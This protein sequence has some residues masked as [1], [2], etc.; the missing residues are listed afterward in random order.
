MDRLN[1][2]A[3]H[4]FARHET[5]HPRYGWFSKA[6]L[7]A[8]RA[9]I[10]GKDLFLA[11]DATVELGV[12]KNM[13]K[14][15]RFWGWAAKLLAEKENPNNTRVPLTV[16]SLNG[17]AI[18]DENNG[19]DP[20]IELPGTLWVLHWWMLR[21]ITKLPVWWLTFH[22]FG[23]VEFIEED[24]IKFV[25][26]EIDKAGWKRPS[27]SSIRKD[28]SCLLRM[29]SRIGEDSASIDDLL[30]CPM[31]ELGLIE[32]SRGEKNRY[33]FVLGSKPTLP[34]LVLVY[35][36]LDWM[37]LQGS[38]SSTM[39]VNRLATAIGS[40]GRAF[41]MNEAS[42][43]ETLGRIQTSFKTVRLSMGAGVPMLACDG[44]PLKE[45]EKALSAYYRR[46]N[47]RGNVGASFGDDAVLSPTSKKRN[48]RRKTDRAYSTRI[49]EMIKQFSNINSPL[50]QKG[51]SK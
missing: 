27:E 23:A 19:L 45:A 43:L 10:E 26:D 4:A 41:R 5:F 40:P 12:G 42:L 1:D 39:T 47:C 22:R 32:P 33:R 17:V 28:V 48:P 7:A 16:P 46:A 49:S 51:K 6:Y 38:A 24:L 29:Y 35:A 34:D 15:I 25:M 30:D 3:E 9:A 21:P 11:E 31:R 44:D 8:Q 36:C 37:A 20:Y 14:A 50:K 2:A 13:V 18:F